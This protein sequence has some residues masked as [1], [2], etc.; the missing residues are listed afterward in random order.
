MVNKHG[1]G[2]G[3]SHDS[4]T[5][6]REGSALRCRNLTCT[7]HGRPILDR[8]DLDVAHGELVALTGPSGSGKTTLL[9]LLSGILPVIQGEAT[10][11]GTSLGGL[12]SRR[13]YLLRQITVTLVP[14]AA[15][16]V[17]RLTAVDNVLLPGR[18]A[19]VT[20]SPERAARELSALGCAD[21]ARQDGGQLSAGERA[22]VGLARGVATDAPIL[23]ADE[24][25]GNLDHDTACSV[26]ER[27]RR[28]ADD[29]RRAVLVA[30]HDPAL[31]EAADRVVVLDGGRL[32]SATDGPAPA[33]PAHPSVKEHVRGGWL[34]RSVAL[35]W[36]LSRGQRGRELIGCVTFAVLIGVILTLMGLLT[37]VENALTERVLGDA[38]VGTLRVEESRLTLGPLDLDLGGRLTSRL[39]DD[40]RAA[41]ATLPGVAAVHPQRYSSFPL[42][43]S[44]RFMDLSMSTD[45]V[46]E[47]LEADWL[48][49]DVDPEKFQWDPSQE[50]EPIPAVVSEALVE[51][52]SDGILRSQGLP[53][54]KARQL[55]GLGLDGQLGRSSFVRTR[56]ADI[57]HVRFEIVGVS[58]RVSPVALAVPMAV[59][60]HYDQAFAGGEGRALA[61]SS[62]VIELADLRDA[63]SVVEGVEELGLRVDRGDGLASHVARG[64]RFLGSVWTVVGVVLLVLFV[65]LYAQLSAAQLRLRR[66]D[67]DLLQ[68]MGAT[69]RQVLGLAVLWSAPVAVVGGLSGVVVALVGGPWLGAWVVDRV[70]DRIGLG[71]GEVFELGLGSA[72]LVALAV[73][74][75]GV[76][77]AL[78]PTVRWV[79]R[80]L[81]GRLRG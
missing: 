23:L 55:K 80:P 30:T 58:D 39:D 66:P 21:L 61:Y 49:A 69:P 38:P 11:G 16:L 34:V 68:A 37:G 1:D 45:A 62:L 15:W 81:D 77:L 22:R 2:V 19:G 50:G 74:V 79:T 44:G 8:V 63:A 73:P 76:V 67:L 29:E 3:G 54:V 5:I 56:S 78:L 48:A 14:Q 40:A 10:V 51:M 13:R 36:T 6:R 72:A 47:G 18:I 24:P 53:R 71:L 70:H 65:G 57:H 43:L 41:V 4:A 32:V 52:A 42:V 9:H 64:F 27:L 20:A 60:E 31:I 12:P 59:V 75:A 33:R 25:T 17:P 46:L 35:S 28:A 7:L 26:T